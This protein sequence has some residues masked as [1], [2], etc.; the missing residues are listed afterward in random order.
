ME[1]PG[2]KGVY[3]LLIKI[4]EKIEADVGALGRVKLDEGYYLY[5]GS[6]LGPGG[7]KARISRHFRKSKKLKWHIDLL[8][9]SEN[10]RIIGVFCAL[11]NEKYECKIVKRLIELGATAPIKN[12]GSTDCSENCPA[13]LL[14][15][16][17]LVTVIVANILKAYLSLELKPVM[18][19]DYGYSK[20]VC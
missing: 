3:T 9:V 5:V 2:E 16:D 7:L 14:K 1:I 10:S 8:L 17:K 19:F 15:Y 13:H 12:F 6:A 20:L 11:T 18:V 4:G